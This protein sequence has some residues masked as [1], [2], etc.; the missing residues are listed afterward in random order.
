MARRKYQYRP[1]WRIPGVKPEVAYRTLEDLRRRGRLNASSL[2]DAAESPDHPMH[3]AFEWDDAKAG[4]EYR[5]D[6]ARRYIRVVQEVVD[7]EP[8]RSIYV[9]TRGPDAGEGNYHRLDSIA[10]SADLYVLALEEANRRLASAYEAVNEL[11]RVAEQ[12]SRGEDQVAKLLLA[13]QALSAAQ[14]AI[15]KLN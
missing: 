13:A 6:Q 4:R 1:G 7:D 5:L 11:R 9:H 15:A 2:V 10:K 8:P 14:T 3:P 12:E